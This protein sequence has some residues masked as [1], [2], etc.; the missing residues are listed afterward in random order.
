MYTQQDL[1]LLHE[2]GISQDLI[3]TQLN[4]FVT[5]FPYLSIVAPASVE[6]GIM[7]VGK[8]EEKTY[9]KAWR[10]FLDSGKKV[11]K[12]VPASGAASRMFKDLYAFLDADYNVPTTPFEKEFFDRI[13]QFAFFGSLDET[14]KKLFG[15]NVVTLYNEGRYKEVVSALLSP[16]GLD[17]GN[18]PKG[19]LLFHKYPEGNRT[20]VGEH[21]TEGTR[22]AKN[23]SGEVDVH[24][25]VSPEHMEMFKLLVASRKLNYEFKL[26]ATFSVSYSIQKPSTDTIAVDMDNKPFREEDGSM[27]FRPGGHGALIENLNEIDSDIIFIKNID[28]VVPDRMKEDEARYKKLLG[29]VLVTMQQRSHDYLNRL[30]SGKATTEELAEMLAFTENELSISH[31]GQFNSDDALKEYLKRKLDRPFRV[32]GMVKNQG[33]PGGGPFITVNPDGTAS[34]QILESSQIDK[35]DPAAMEA[36]K[37]GSHF[38]PVDVVCGVKNNRGDKYNLTQFVDRNTGFISYKSKNGKELK[39]LELPGLWNGAMS[40]WNTIFVEVPVSTFNPVK[41]VNDLLRPEHQ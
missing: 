6:R 2:K 21:L 23:K 25:T 1:E 30:E 12:F 35:D 20:P 36:F 11:T 22:Y 10:D 38:N 41:V 15:E 17:Y 3:N 33:E 7:K 8:E 18:Y 34:P 4:Y 29:G 28:N 26:G 31:P 19:L 16:S 5:G 14:C 40:D 9:L 27:L 24:F 32:C 39:A 37:K 13:Q